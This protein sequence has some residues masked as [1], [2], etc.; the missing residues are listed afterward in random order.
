V[1]RWESW[2]AASPVERAFETVNFSLR[3][4]DKSLPVN[5]TPSE[6]AARLTSLLPSA[7]TEIQALLDEH[8]TSLYTSR[9][10]N[11]L[12]AKRAALRLRWRALLERAR[13]TFEGRPLES[14]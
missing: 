10:A 2:T 9:T 4:L 8:Q 6:R 1:L 3:L 5:A 11:V 14:P 13:Y 7:K 12:R